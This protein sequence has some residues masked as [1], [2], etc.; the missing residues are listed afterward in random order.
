MC[1]SEAVSVNPTVRLE[2]GN[3][4]PYVDMAAVT[5]GSRCAYA[6]EQRRFSGG[7]S[8]FEDG[9]TIM[10]RITPCLE[11]GKI[12]RYCAS[13][14]EGVAYGSTE[15]IV[16]R[17][18]PDVTETDFA[19]YLTLSEEVRGYAISQMTGTS[20]RQRVPTES[21][22]HLTV[23]I[24]P[25]PEQRAIAHV[26]GTLDDKIE[27]NRRMND[28]LEAMARA[29]FKDWFVDFG[30]V[31]AKMEGRE[32]YL[33][34]ETWDLF[35]DALDDRDKPVGW[36]NKPLDE[37]ADFLNGL[38]LQKFPAS[39]LEDSL[40]VI[41]I[42]ELRNGIS[43]KSNRA[44]RKMPEKYVIE[45]GDFLFS[46]S[47][48]LL[49]KFWT[50]GEGALNQHL[51]KITS[52]K[53]PSWFFSQ[54]IYHHLDEFRAVAASKATTM[55]HIQRGHL[56]EAMTSCPP[57]ETLGKLGEAIAPLVERT[58]KNSIQNRTLAQTRD[59]LLPRLLSGEVRLHEAE[60]GIENVTREFQ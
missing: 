4:Y 34:S 44:S 50:E 37:I 5:A 9:D 28:T 56:K 38:A 27:L 1:F 7:G 33:D 42:T 60:R 35:P 40:P 24:P 59:L 58:I 57:D 51:F 52:N 21:L 12:A 23:P 15:F 54:W 36:E 3:A 47:G 41:K 10:A 6:V 14:A 45:D 29:V 11:N 16:I 31:H 46:W 32:P 48:S 39:D 2:R 55:G 19:Y 17:G 20:G 26:L 13:D 30:P 18:R 53:Y 43:R 49:A 22:C 8:R 25:L